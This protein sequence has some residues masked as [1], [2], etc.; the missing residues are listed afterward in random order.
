MRLLVAVI[1]TICLGSA[2]QAG[3]S[4]L[5]PDLQGANVPAELDV[6]IQFKQPGIV[7]SGLS[8]TQCGLRMAAESRGSRSLA[9]IFR[10]RRGVGCHP[11]PVWIE[12]GDCSRHV[13]SAERQTAELGLATL[14]LLV[15]AVLPGGGGRSGHY[16]SDE[17][18]CRLAPVAAGSS[19]YGAGV[20]VVSRAA[21]ADVCPER[22]D[23]GVRRPRHRPIGRSP[24]PTSSE[25]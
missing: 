20:C 12:Y 14:P 18:C 10:G 6:I 19:A 24:G 5:S 1:G 15:A 17:P 4:K 13:G 23:A 7:Q 16:D 11:G 9:R 2:C 25:L 3:N 21:G 8:G 22:S